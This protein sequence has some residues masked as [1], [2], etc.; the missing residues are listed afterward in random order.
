MRKDF[1]RSP[2][3]T[4]EVAIATYELLKARQWALLQA[5]MDEGQDGPSD[6]PVADAVAA[7]TV[8]VKQ[9]GLSDEEV[10][11]SVQIGLEE[12]QFDLEWQ[13]QTAQDFIET[14]KEFWDSI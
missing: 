5:R 13:K 12:F 6:D 11:R 8:L 4:M 10:G 3:T 1:F 2:F 9:G 7:L 14:V